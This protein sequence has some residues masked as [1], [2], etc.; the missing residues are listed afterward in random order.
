MDAF[1]VVAEPS[2]R[3]ILDLLRWREHSAGELVDALPELTQPAVSRHLRILREAGLV[4]VS[5]DAQRR[6]YTLRASGLAE[7][8][9]WLAPYRRE[10][11]DRLD[12][13]EQHLD[14][15]GRTSDE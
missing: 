10:W 5:P 2:R 9:A 12:A 4:D 7:I 11:A 8:E 15:K 1:T 14:T 13:L 6:I 3:T